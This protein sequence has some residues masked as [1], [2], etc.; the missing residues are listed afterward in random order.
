M[1]MKEETDGREDVNVD[2][3]EVNVDGEDGE[4]AGDGLCTRILL[5]NIGVMPRGRQGQSG[6]SG[7]GGDGGGENGGAGGYATGAGQERGGHHTPLSDEPEELVGGAG[8]DATGGGQERGGHHTP[9]FYEPEQ[10]V[11]D[12][13]LELVEQVK[14]TGIAS[15]QRVERQLQQESQRERP[16]ERL[17]EALRDEVEETEHN[18]PIIAG[19]V[20]MLAAVL[21]TVDGNSILVGCDGGIFFFVPSL[22]LF[23]SKPCY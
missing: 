19:I 14:A 15:I 22:D 4:F 1:G 11:G 10:L 20:M 3:G 23:G 12:E 8:G 21:V 7:I 2:G 6:G 18:I 5:C 13:V 9:V 16:N 17:M